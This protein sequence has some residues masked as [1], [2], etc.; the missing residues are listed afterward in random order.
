MV[1]SFRSDAKVHQILIDLEHAQFKDKDLAV[2]ASKRE[3][4][5][6]THSNVVKAVKDPV[7]KVSHSGYCG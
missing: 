4:S 2:F 6:E 5:G 1:G 7:Q 3:S